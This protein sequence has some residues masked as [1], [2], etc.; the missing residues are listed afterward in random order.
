MARDVHHSAIIDSKVHLGERVRIGPYCVL[1]GRIQIGNDT[2]LSSHI[3]IGDEA[4]HGT[5][6]FEFH[7]APNPTGQ[8]VIGSNV[9]IREFTTINR[10]MKTVTF[11][12]DHCYIMARSHVSHDNFL[13]PG[14]IL[15]TGAC[16]GGWTKVMIGA[17]I[18]LNAVTHQFTTIGMHAMVAANA[19]VVKDLPP[20]SKFIPGKP[21]GIN[22]H[23][24]EKLNL[25]PFSI[26]AEP[27]SSF[28]MEFLSARD[29]SRDWH[30]YVEPEKK[31]DPCL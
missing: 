7:P 10:P 2:V 21:L 5:E 17:N 31:E 30:R 11:I 4:E 1:R 8:I 26:A 12:G 28:I 13:E 18:G 29:K 25:P 3:S 15:S 16:L 19:T 14:V 22:T 24:I 9:A 23:K 27:Y 20:F 6:R